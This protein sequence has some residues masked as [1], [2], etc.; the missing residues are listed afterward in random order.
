MGSGVQCMIVQK[1]APPPYN[2]V[3]QEQS[4]TS[5]CGSRCRSV[6]LTNITHAHVI[7]RLS[8]CCF[9]ALS[10]LSLS[11][12][13]FLS[14]CP[15]VLC[16]AHQL[17]CRRNR[18]GMKPLHSRTMRNIAPWRYTTP[19]TNYEPKLFDKVRLLRDFCSDLPG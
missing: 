15:P 2:I 17:P 3:N 14:H 12:L 5:H 16:P 8:V 9:L 19:L 11:R 6:C 7:T 13:Y 1:K 4:D 10:S 18:R